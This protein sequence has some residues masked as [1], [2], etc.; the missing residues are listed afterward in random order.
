[1]FCVPVLD[2]KSSGYHLASACSTQAVGERSMQAVCTSSCCESRRA[3]HTRTDLVLC[4]TSEAPEASHCVHKRLFKK[5]AESV[6]LT[7][8]MVASASRC[9]RISQLHVGEVF[10][11][12]SGLRDAWHRAPSFLQRICLDP[13]A[14]VL[15]RTATT[16]HCMTRVSNKLP[17]VHVALSWT[18]HLSTATTF[19]AQQQIPLVEQS[20]PLTVKGGESSVPASCLRY[21]R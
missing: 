7:L 2:K 6:S 11:I 9:A 18:C 10:G 19:R 4:G 8:L 20:W 12:G 15:T 13:T 5:A 17:R 21:G 3:R 14:C 16:C 1:M